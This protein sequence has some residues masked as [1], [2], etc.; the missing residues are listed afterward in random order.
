ML[1]GFGA[2]FIVLIADKVKSVLPLQLVPKQTLPLIVL[3][4]VKVCP[5][6]VVMVSLTGTLMPP[7][8]PVGFF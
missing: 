1:N 4:L 6:I 3:V 8:I 2:T 7:Q 5:S